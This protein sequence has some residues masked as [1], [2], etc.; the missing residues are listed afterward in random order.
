MDPFGAHTSPRSAQPGS[1][2]RTGAISF[3]LGSEMRTNARTEMTVSA[4]V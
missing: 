2:F 3:F 1:M 4:C